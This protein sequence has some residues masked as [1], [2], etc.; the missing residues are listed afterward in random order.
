[1]TYNREQKWVICNFK[2]E[3]LKK[4]G[5]GPVANKE[6]LWARVLRDKYV[7]HEHS[8]HSPETS[9]GISH[10]ESDAYLGGDEFSPLLA[11]R[12]WMSGS[13]LV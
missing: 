12:G 7:W 8:P 4:M 1:M 3:K 2:Y 6:P 9:L 5:W 10:L 13:I 11:V